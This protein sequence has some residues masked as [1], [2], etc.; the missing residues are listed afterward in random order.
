V[1]F[2]E[3]TKAFVACYFLFVALHYTARLSALRARKG[4]KHAPIGKATTRNGVHQIL[5]RVFRLAILLLM[6][7]RVF[8]DAVD[9]AL[10]P[11]HALLNIPVA[12]AGILLMGAG[13]ALV[14]YGHSYLN[15]EW[16]SGVGGQPGAV[17]VTDGPYAVSRNPIFAGILVAQFGTFLAAPSVFTLVCL[18]VGVTVILRQV[19][20]EEAALEARHGDAYTAYRLRVPRWIA[21]G[22][23]IGEPAVTRGGR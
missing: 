23:R 5:F 22:A 10:L 1:P 13:L 9:S 11:I 19:G 8:S 17:L 4:Y 20:V 15:D 3:F 18:A 12:V 2:L 7:A 6:G 14:D 21:P 16:R